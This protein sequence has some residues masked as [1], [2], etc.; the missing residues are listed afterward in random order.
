[1]PSDVVRDPHKPPLTYDG[2]DHN[3]RER[4][5]FLAQVEV[6]ETDDMEEQQCFLQYIVG[7]VGTF[8][9]RPPEENGGELMNEALK[10]D[11]QEELVQAFGY[12]TETPATAPA[13]STSGAAASTATTAATSS[14]SSSSAA[15]SGKH[16]VKHRVLKQRNTDPP[17]PKTL[18]RDVSQ[19]MDRVAGEDNVDMREDD[20]EDHEQELMTQA[21]KK[22]PGADPQ[23]RPAARLPRLLGHDGKH[24][25]FEDE[26][27]GRPARH[28]LEDRREPPERQDRY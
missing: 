21:Q 9:P 14:A 25:G 11:I 10:G 19:E 27:L 13:G 22:Q 7:E 6:L 15:T 20:A 16:K 3:S 2:V 1:M 18:N 17:A 4:H 12:K 26:H 24:A 8:T 5:P 23:H 28:G